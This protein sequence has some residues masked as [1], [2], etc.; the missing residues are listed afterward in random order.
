M[1]K[2]QRSELLRQRFRATGGIPYVPGPKRA[3]KPLREPR[4]R[5]YMDWPDIVPDSKRVPKYWLKAEREKRETL[6]PK[7][8]ARVS[9]L[10]R[11]AAHY[12]KRHP[13]KMVGV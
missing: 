4:G 13:R 5:V 10:I 12:P 1:D 6:S 11:I 7:R 2:A 9:P 8:L 3:P